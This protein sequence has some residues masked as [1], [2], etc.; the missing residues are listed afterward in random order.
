M[1]AFVDREL[2]QLHT[3]SHS[4]R[5]RDMFGRMVA[6][7]LVLHAISSV[8]LLSPQR[9]AMNMPPVSYID[10][11][12]MKFQEPADSIPAREQKSAEIAENK[13]IAEEREEPQPPPVEPLSEAGKLQRDVKQSLADAESHPESLQERAFGLGLSNGYFSSL[14]EGETLRGDIREYYFTM[15]REINEKWWINKES[16]QTGLRGALINIV[17]ARNGVILQKML[18]RS[19]GNPAFDKAMLKSIDAASPLPPLPE[20]YELEYFSAPLRF[21]GPLDFFTS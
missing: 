17:V 7:S 9:G 15:L 18:V 12:D 8:I 3:V 5:T 2:Q 1:D 11:K 13:E 20:S 6:I 21:T 4:R 10:L 19:S 16:R 14:S